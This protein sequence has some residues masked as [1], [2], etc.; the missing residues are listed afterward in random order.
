MQLVENMVVV[1]DL[2]SIPN[3]LIPEQCCAGSDLAKWNKQPHL[4]EFIG[5]EV[6]CIEK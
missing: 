3:V 6:F 5:M 2:A 4:Q 1:A